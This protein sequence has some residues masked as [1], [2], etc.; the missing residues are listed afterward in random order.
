[1]RMAWCVVRNP[2]QGEERMGTAGWCARGGGG[3][4]WKGGAVRSHLR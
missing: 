4:V 3:E 1:M 2:E